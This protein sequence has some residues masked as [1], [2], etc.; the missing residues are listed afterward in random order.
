MGFDRATVNKV[1]R[2][3]IEPG[4]E[5]AR[6]A[7]R[8]LEAGGELWRRWAAF[9]AAQSPTQP[10]PGAR[11]AGPPPPSGVGHEAG[12]SSYRCAIGTGSTGSARSKP[13]TR[14]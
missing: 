3:A 2:G 9:D 1:E 14:L 12:R 5:F 6:Q 11:P 13:N 8:A 4:R 10:R 7:E